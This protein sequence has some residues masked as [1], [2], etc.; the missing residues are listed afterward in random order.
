[1]SKV[2][3]DGRSAAHRVTI[4]NHKGGV[5]K[6]TLTM[7]I[8]S[9]L[10][11]IGRK[12]LLVDSDPQCNLTSYLFSDSDV[13]KLLDDSDSIEGATIWSAVKP[14]S[15]AIGEIKI[16]KTLKRWER[17]YV[18]PGDIR[19]SQFEADLNEFWAQCFQR[20]VK[21]FRGV[22]AISELVNSIS[23]KLNIDYVFYDTG[24]NIGALNRSILL[25]CDY[26]IIPAACD[27]FSLRALKTLGR[28]MAEWITSWETI[29]AIAPEKIYL[30]PGRPTFLGYIPERFK[31]YG[32][33]VVD[34]Q[35]R[36]LSRIEKEIFG[37]I[38]SVLR[39]IDHDL[40]P[41][42]MHQLKLGEIKDYG[43]IMQASQ[44]EG[45]PLYDVK[46]APVYQRVSAK[47]AL[48]E[49]ADKIEKL[50]AV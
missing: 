50:V 49:I 3:R 15:E 8:A 46:S 35:S 20:K 39:N 44:I 9:A 2:K 11:D 18:I 41:R 21:G 45:V 42:N 34:E 4:F 26:F 36:F 13:D 29:T 43:K 32:G 7:N 47:D 27:L 14:V 31:I 23:N 40:A 30:L 5:G 10:A 1:M 33:R 19:L 24:P 38:V 48:Y 17:L 16:I 28:T 22:S 12:V 37:Q 25:D 6:T